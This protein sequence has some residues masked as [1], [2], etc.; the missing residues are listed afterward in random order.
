V[1]LQILKD[2][3]PSAVVARQQFFEFS[4]GLVSPGTLANADC[5]GEGPDESFNV[6]RNRGYSVDS[7]IRWL[8]KRIKKNPPYAPPG[9]RRRRQQ[10]QHTAK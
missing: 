8:E 9:P 10:R 7:A 5:A 3:W 4:G 2:K 1:N 6:G